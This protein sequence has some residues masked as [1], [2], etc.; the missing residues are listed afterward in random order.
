MKQIFNLTA[1]AIM[2][3]S[4]IAYLGGLYVLYR[5][6]RTK[7]SEFILIG[8]VWGFVNLVF[9]TMTYLLIKKWLGYGI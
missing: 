1:N 2:F 6:L 9:W 8:I 3:I 4:V 7:K 5:G